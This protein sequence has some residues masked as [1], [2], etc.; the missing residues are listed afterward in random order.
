M[1]MR[2]PVQACTSAAAEVSAILEAINRA[3]VAR[4]NGN[5]L[6]G[7]KV[8]VHDRSQAPESTHGSISSSRYSS[9][10]SISGEL[11][12]IIGLCLFLSYK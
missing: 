1:S 10:S 12:E 2:R 3:T 6:Q 9:Q 7:I 4:V 11:C 5:C 8:H